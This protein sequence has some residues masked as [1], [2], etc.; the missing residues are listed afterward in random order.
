LGY[1]VE[2]QH[3]FKGFLKGF[4]GLMKRLLEPHW[5]YFKVF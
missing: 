3:G 4:I 2:S 5:V 1:F